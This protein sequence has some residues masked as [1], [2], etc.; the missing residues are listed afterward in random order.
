VRVLS[1][2]D[3]EIHYMYK[4]GILSNYGLTEGFEYTA[5]SPAEAIARVFLAWHKAVVAAYGE[6]EA[7]Q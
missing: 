4:A 2:L 6:W 1:P 5:Y 3:G 7:T